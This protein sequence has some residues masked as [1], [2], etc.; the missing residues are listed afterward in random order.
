MLGAAVATRVIRTGRLH[1]MHHALY[2][3]TLSTTVLAVLVGMRR[4]L[5]ATQ[6]LVPALVP[7]VIIPF[8]GTHTRR[9][10]LIA[11][12][13]APFIAAGALASRR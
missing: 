6:A 2:V 4:D 12:S 1:W 13:A 3:A 5:P 10:P 8:A 9:H 11:L 7:L